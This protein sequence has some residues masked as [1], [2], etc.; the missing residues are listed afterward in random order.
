MGAALNGQPRRYGRGC[1]CRATYRL[2]LSRRLRRG[3]SRPWRDAGGRGRRRTGRQPQAVWLRRSWCRRGRSRW[4]NISA[5]TT[6]TPTPIHPQV[7]LETSLSSSRYLGS[8]GSDTGGSV[9]P[10]S[11][12]RGSCS[13]GSLMVSSNVHPSAAKQ[14]PQSGNV[15]ISAGALLGKYSRPTAVARASATLVDNRPHASRRESLDDRV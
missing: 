8:R 3:R 14:P 13:R 12:I 6:T 15:P 1:P 9:S 10:R 11:I 2:S 4:R 5:R 7:A